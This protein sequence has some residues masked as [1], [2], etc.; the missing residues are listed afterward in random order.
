VPDIGFDDP[1][2]AER[3]ARQRLSLVISLRADRT[4]LPSYV[5]AAL[6]SFAKSAG[7][8]IIA[9]SQV[10]EDDPRTFEMAKAMN[11]KAVP[12]GSRDSE[13]QEVVARALYDSSIV[14]VSDRLHVLILAAL[15]GGAPV[16]IASGPSGKVANHFIVVG[17]AD[18]S[19]DT[20]L[21]VDE[22]SVVKALSA[23]AARGGEVADAVK[24]A[25]QRLTHVQQSLL[26]R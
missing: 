2:S 22:V 17:L 23:A 4:P 21:L 16:E 15:H 12:W 19:Y 5:L 9:L 1:D 3:A 10:A 13:D 8:N 7:L 6:Q 14:V 24:Y 18:V 20:A 25:R 11:A 26:E